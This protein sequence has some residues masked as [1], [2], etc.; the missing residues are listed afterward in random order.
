MTQRLIKSYADRNKTTDFG[1][2]AIALLLI[3][4]YT[5]F[6]AEQVANPEGNGIDYYLINKNE[7]Y[8]DNIL[9][10][11]SALLEVAGIRLET[12]NNTVNRKIKEKLER[13]KNI[14]M[15]FQKLLI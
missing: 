6:V 2:C 13:L 3:K 1:A 5:D 9:Y 15:I 11:Y 4:E 10:N 12:K 8:D 14:T 7:Y